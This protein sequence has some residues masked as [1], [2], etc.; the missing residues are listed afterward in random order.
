MNSGSSVCGWTW[1]K[2]NHWV[3]RPC[4]SILEPVI[5]TDDATNK[6]HVTQCHFQTKVKDMACLFQWHSKHREIN[7]SLSR[8][9]AGREWHD[10]SLCNPQKEVEPGIKS[11]I[12]L[13]STTRTP[14]STAESASHI[15]PDYIPKSGKPG[16]RGERKE[17]WRY[18]RRL[19]TPLRPQLSQQPRPLQQVIYTFTLRQIKQLKYL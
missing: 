18:F 1:G 10:T 11:N 14:S 4:R 8:S 5:L 9:M 13:L 7:M 16:I 15:F 19:S 2:K 3:Y 17:G 12:I 6:Q